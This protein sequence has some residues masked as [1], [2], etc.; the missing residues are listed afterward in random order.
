MLLS[1]NE[2]FIKEYN[3]FSGK[4]NQIENEKIKS[5]LDSLLKRLVDEV[6]SI[7]KQHK[8]LVSGRKTLLEVNDSRSKLQTIR[9]QL[10][11]KINECEAAGV[12]KKY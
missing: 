5:E 8:D 1:K 6:Q 11:K 4:I 3:I 9:K 10:H 2:N 7:D 12:I